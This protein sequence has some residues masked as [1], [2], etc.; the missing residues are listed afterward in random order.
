[1][2]ILSQVSDFNHL[3]KLLHSLYDADHYDYAY[4]WDKVQL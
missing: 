3:K 1:M 4:D 2:A